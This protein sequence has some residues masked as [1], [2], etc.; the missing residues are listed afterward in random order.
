MGKNIDFIKLDIQ[1]A[2]GVA[3]EGMKKMLARNPKI[4]ILMEFWPM[5]IRE[6]GG[7]PPKKF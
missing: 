2:E 5:G 1:G 6:C 4:V 7:I 3:L